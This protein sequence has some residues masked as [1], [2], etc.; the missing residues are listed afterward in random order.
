MENSRVYYIYYLLRGKIR[1]D[2]I[3]EHA[4]SRQG[5]QVLMVLSLLVYCMVV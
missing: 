2:D 3:L 1:D 5:E 4:V